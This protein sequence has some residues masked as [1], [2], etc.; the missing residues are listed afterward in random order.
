MLQ[1]LTAHFWCSLWCA[2]QD[3]PFPHT[4]CS[5]YLGVVQNKGSLPHHKAH[6]EESVIYTD[7]PFLMP[8]TP[9]VSLSVSPA[10]RS[11]LKYP[12][13]NFGTQSMHFCTGLSYDFVFQIH[14]AKDLGHPVCSKPARYPEITKMNGP[15]Y[16]VC[17]EL[18]DF[19][20][21]VLAFN[22]CIWTDL[23]WDLTHVGSF[24]CIFIFQRC[25]EV[26]E[27]VFSYSIF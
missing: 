18:M 14:L 20:L 3:V 4:K 27:K 21:L 12:Y 8:L 9:A 23:T 15:W 16:L 26:L 17:L 13:D 7:V 10:F 2:L 25:I 5:G 11:L 19:L 1:E 24:Y 22:W 6:K